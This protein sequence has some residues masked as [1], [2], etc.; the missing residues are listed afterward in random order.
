LSNWN[1]LAELDPLWTILSEPDKKFGKW[2]TAEFFSTG[3]REAE[4]VLAM[5]KASNLQISYGR[6]LDFG[7]GV[8]RMTRGFSKFFASC[9]G[10]D[11]S[12]KMVALARDLNAGVVN[13]EFAVSAE[14]R[15]PF[16]DGDFDFV[17][18]VLVLQHLPTREMILNYI[19][20]FIRV[21]KDDGIIVFQL[22][23]QVPF[24]RRFQLRR[25][26]WTILSALGVPS[27][28]LFKKAGLAPIQMNGIAKE[29]VTKFVRGRGAEVR[30]ETNYDP[31]GT[32]IHGYY[33]L[34]VKTS[35]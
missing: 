29:K 3:E 11:A 5:C 2:D 13:C 35:G 21:A 20:E 4:R 7:C 18:T 26:L 23:L 22:P 8:G 34:V 10:L 24:R 33:Y 25:R 28:W 31:K 14:S 32:E 9:V 19:G 27:P 15:L 30:A 16:K 6:L 1:A 17:F 12:E